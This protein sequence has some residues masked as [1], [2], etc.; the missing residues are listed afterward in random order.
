M[1]HKPKC[2]VC[3]DIAFNKQRQSFFCKRCSKAYTLGYQA[4]YHSLLYKV[5]S[6]KTQV[7][8]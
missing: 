3:G 8:T 1:T 7:Y 2:K 4:G 5:K 6:S